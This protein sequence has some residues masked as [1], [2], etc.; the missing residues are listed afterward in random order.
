MLWDS[1]PLTFDLPSLGASRPESVF[2]VR[3]QSDK[4]LHQAV[5]D[6]TRFLLVEAVREAR[7]NTKQA[8]ARLG[9]SRDTIYRLFR[10]LGLNREV[11]TDSLQ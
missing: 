4:S 2:S 9:I 5:D 7:G 1:G 10:R 3:L 11:R 8:A 6:V